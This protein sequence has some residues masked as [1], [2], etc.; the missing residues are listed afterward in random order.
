MRLTRARIVVA[1]LIVGV[2]AV[3]AIVVDQFVLSSAAVMNPEAPPSVAA[4]ENQ[5]GYIILLPTNKPDCLAYDPASVATTPDSESSTG[6]SLN[7]KLVATG[8]GTCASWAGSSVNIAEAP[9]LASL[10]G[11]VSTDSQGRM[12]FARVSKSLPDGTE[13][14][15]QWHCAEMMCRISGTLNQTLTEDVLKNLAN[16]FQVARLPN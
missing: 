5:W 12:Q 3:I 7:L 1:I 13:V 14:I 9:A 8:T 10:T 11:N 16:S 15:L 4:I 2:I 6:K